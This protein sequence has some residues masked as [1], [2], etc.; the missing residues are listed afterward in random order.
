MT[1]KTAISAPAT[2]ANA[3]QIGGDHY[4]TDFEHW[5]WIEMNGIGYLE[6]CATKYLSRWR[7]KN[8]VIDLQKAIHYVDKIIE[9]H[10]DHDREN[11]LR[12]SQKTGKIAPGLI[13]SAQ[14]F[15]DTNGLTEAEAKAVILIG[16]WDGIDDLVK[17][18]IIIVA[19]I[20]GFNEMKSRAGIQD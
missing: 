16:L 9:M 8:G 17:A 19:L 4:K 2:G 3:R 18:R 5:D 7:K 11:R 20:E 15:C 14:S 10:D 6:G 13:P 1:K 12:G